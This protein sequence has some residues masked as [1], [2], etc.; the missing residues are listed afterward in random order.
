MPL[1]HRLVSLLLVAATALGTVAHAG[2]PT[3]DLQAEVATIWELAQDSLRAALDRVQAAR[4]DLGPD[5]PYEAR[6]KLLLTEA[7]IREDLGQL[8]V[9]YTLQRESL[10]LAQ[11]HHD[12]AGAS[13]AVT[14]HVRKSAGVAYRR[15][16]A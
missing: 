14:G 16:D 12:A 1:P 3:I 9:A 7:W 15:R 13:L 2:Q 4:R 5:A 11:A 10:Q 6:Q 8:D